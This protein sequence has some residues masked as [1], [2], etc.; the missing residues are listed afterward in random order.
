VCQIAPML[1]IAGTF[2]VD[3]TR[4]DE[5]IAQRT[6]GMRESRTEHGCI[7]YVVSADP[8]EPGRVYLFERWESKEHL[9]PHLAKV[10]APATP[11]PSAVPVLSAEL[12]QYEIAAVGPVGS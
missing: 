11:D 2:E 3:P 4:R 9:A 5:F 10:R 7:D 12:L 6:A 8:L 1:I